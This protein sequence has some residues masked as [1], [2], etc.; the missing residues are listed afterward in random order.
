MQEQEN[1]LRDYPVVIQLPVLWG[2]MDA[3]RHVNNV[4]YFR[5]FESVR[6]VY[7]DKIEMYKY[8]QEDKIGPILAS[9]SCNFLKPLRYPDTISIGCRTTR[10]SESE[11][12]QEYGLFSQQMQKL[13][14]VGTA[15][16]VAYDYRAFKR[17]TFP[18]PVI[19]RI[20]Q[21]EEH[22]RLS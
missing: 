2:H 3:F 10:L 11:M 7:G 12:D 20:L 6:I 4:A 16:I 21:L 18:Q 17:A 19:E 14:A 9:T 22:L 13:A 5:Y 1:P 15:K 8:L